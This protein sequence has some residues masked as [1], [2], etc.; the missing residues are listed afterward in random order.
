[1]YYQKSLLTI[2][3]TNE[4][5]YKMIKLSHPI[6]VKEFFILISQYDTFSFHFQIFYI[7]GFSDFLLKI[8]C[9]P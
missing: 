8:S 6:I 7:F 4:D 3:R 2:F 9:S 1:M 5:E